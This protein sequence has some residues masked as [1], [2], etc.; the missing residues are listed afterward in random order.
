MGN[1]IR[2]LKSEIPRVDIDLS[3]SAAI[4]LLCNAID[5]FINERFVAA[6]TVIAERSED[7]VRS[8]DVIIAFANSS[9]VRTVLLQA[10]QA[11]KSFRVIVL[12]D[13]PLYEG[14]NLARFLVDHDIDTQ[15]EAF[16]GLYYHM[17][18]ATKVFLG[19]HA[20]L[21][22]GNLKS[23]AGTAQVA[24][25]A[26]DRGVPVIVCCESVKFTERIALD[27]LEENELLLLE[28]DGATEMA[29]ARHA[30]LYDVT[31]AEYISLVLTEDGSVPPSSVSVVHALRNDT[32]QA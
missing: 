29:R 2:W 9:V 21:G 27:S 24:L 31:P 13:G 5:D 7:K 28:P 16:T 18:G 3:D 26:K 19:A 22:N 23:R 25:A 11:G 8:G 30:L 6:G 32:G 4:T 15:Y 10:K 1:A 20:M 12:D 17:Q 14:Q